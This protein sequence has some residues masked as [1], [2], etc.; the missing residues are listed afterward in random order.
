MSNRAI[1]F[2]DK[3]N[4]VVH[5]STT[6]ALALL[7][8]TGSF[9]G[10]P[11]TLLLRH[12]ILF[13]LLAPNLIIGLLIQLLLHLNLLLKSHAN[14]SFTMAQQVI[15]LNDIG[16]SL[17]LG[18][19]FPLSVLFVDGKVARIATSYMEAHGART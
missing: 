17:V 14:C 8:N 11:M 2:L 15:C 4:R 5:A 18:R 19:E 1:T 12:G 6:D 3:L 7:F 16:H 9:P 10:H 13:M